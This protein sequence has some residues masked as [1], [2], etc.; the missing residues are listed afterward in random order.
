MIT[1]RIDADVHRAFRHAGLRL[2]TKFKNIPANERPDRFD[3]VLRQTIGM[4]E[5]FNTTTSVPYGITDVRFI[6][7]IGP[8]REV[9]RLFQ[10]LQWCV[11]FSL[12]PPNEV[13]K[14]IVINLCDRV[15]TG[16]GVN[17]PIFPE[18]NISP[19]AQRRILTDSLFHQFPTIPWS[20][21]CRCKIRGG[22]F[23][24][25][26]DGN[27]RIKRGLPPEIVHD[28]TERIWHTF[29]TH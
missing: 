24:L 17:A 22:H 12:D 4:L 13:T 14:S 27:F 16:V 25:I 15:G 5:G 1:S 10:A 28:H 19:A 11:E 23:L 9:F 8:G 6:E 18:G 20:V 2:S 3:V 7:K 29:S 21:Y 26:T